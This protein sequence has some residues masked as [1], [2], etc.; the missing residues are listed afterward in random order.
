MWSNIIYW[1]PNIYYLSV[2]ERNRKNV[3]FVDGVL[4]WIQMNYGYVRSIC[5][6]GDVSR[7][8]KTCVKNDIFTVESI[9]NF[10][11][12]HMTDFCII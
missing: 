4:R 1:I 5:T 7:M 3:E 10:P 12:D 8:L 6:S 2:S 11:R 9:V